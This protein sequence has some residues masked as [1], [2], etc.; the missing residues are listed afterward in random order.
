MEN[1]K[2]HTNGK[3]E[4]EWQDAFKQE[5]FRQDFKLP[6]PEID[7]VVLEILIQDMLADDEVDLSQAKRMLN[8]IGIKT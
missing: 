4:L 3:I 5:I 8:D 7:D 6:E 2:F 1:D